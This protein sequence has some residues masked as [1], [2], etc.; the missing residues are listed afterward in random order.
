VIRITTDTIEIENHGNQIGNDE[1]AGGH[2]LGLQLVEWVVER[3]N[4]HWDEETGETYCRHSIRLKRTN[5]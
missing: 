5:S 4:W 2:G 1:G 3:A